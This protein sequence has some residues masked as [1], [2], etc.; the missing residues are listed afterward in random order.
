M[1]VPGNR[2]QPL[3]VQDRQKVGPVGS[4]SEISALGIRHVTLLSQRG[5]DS[6]QI[7]HEFGGAARFVS[8]NRF[9]EQ[10]RLH[11]AERAAFTHCPELDD[12]RNYIEGEQR[13]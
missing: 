5:V 9:L 12:P 1:A 7:S 6:L 13:G 8:F 11:T 3:V 4:R 2:N 10:K